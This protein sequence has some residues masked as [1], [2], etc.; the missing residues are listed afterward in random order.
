MLSG[1]AVRD[2][3]SAARAADAL[4]ARGPAQVILTMGGDG[5]VVADAEG[6]RHFEALPVKAVDT[7]AAG[8]TFIG[9][10]CAALARNEVRSMPASRSA[11]RPR[12]CA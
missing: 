7:T 5:V 2:T 1:I 6:C 4:R 10:L 11:S 8:D 9:A 12:R 3:A